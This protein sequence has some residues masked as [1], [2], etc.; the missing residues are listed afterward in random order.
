M[1][2]AG[3]A[4]AGNAL[5]T[6]ERGVADRQCEEANRVARSA[7][8]VDVDDEASGRAGC[9]SRGERATRT[10]IDA[11][12]GGHGVGSRS[13][14][15]WFTGHSA[16]SADELDYPQERAR[17]VIRVVAGLLSFAKVNLLEVGTMIA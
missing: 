8:V 1:W 12:A 14:G 15:S 3:S 10:A 16:G 6:E 11:G 13:T 4:G 9:D 7:Q 2:D 17:G 5:V